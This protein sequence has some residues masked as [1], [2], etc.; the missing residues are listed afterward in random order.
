MFSLIYHPSSGNTKSIYNLVQSL[1]QATNIAE[2]DTASA[3]AHFG[4]VLQQ[5]VYKIVYSKRL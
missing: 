3:L 2:V 4:A 1:Y 5:L